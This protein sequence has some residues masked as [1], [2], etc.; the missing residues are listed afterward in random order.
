MKQKQQQKKEILP[1][2]AQKIEKSF[3]TSSFHSHELNI[4][5]I[6]YIGDEE[7]D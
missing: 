5:F 1:L 3:N 6:F 2:P 4:V 7:V